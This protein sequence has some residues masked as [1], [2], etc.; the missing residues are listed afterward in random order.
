MDYEITINDQTLGGGRT[1]SDWSIFPSD[2]TWWYGSVYFNDYNTLDCNSNG[3]S[4]KLY[5][6]DSVGNVI[7][8]TEPI[9]GTCRETT[10]VGFNWLVG[11]PPGN[12]DIFKI[13]IEVSFN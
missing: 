6:Y 13:V 5:A 8:E 9:Y 11:R 10:D 1:I 4:L 2:T 7:D 3:Y 12:T